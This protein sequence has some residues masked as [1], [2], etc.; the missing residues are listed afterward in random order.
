MVKKRANTQSKSDKN[1]MLKN[2]L[3]ASENPILTIGKVISFA[4]VMSSLAFLIFSKSQFVV[5]AI[6]TSMGLILFGV[7]LGLLVARK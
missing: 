3:D 6:P 4:V 2:K 5:Y 1:I 7:V